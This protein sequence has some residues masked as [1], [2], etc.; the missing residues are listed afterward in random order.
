ML[1]LEYCFLLPPVLKF[2]VL[3]LS[4]FEPEVPYLMHDFF[5]QK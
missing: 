1:I 5:L 2:P 4:P 3:L